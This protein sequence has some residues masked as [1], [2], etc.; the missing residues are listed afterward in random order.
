M[1][2]TRVLH[3]VGIKEQGFLLGAETIVEVLDKITDAF[4]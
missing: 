2:D 1:D 3:E 4:E